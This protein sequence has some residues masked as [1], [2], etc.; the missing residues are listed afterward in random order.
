MPRRPGFLKFQFF[1]LPASMF[2][3]A[4]AI[5]RGSFSSSPAAVDVGGGKV[6]E[7]TVKHRELQ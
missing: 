5:I 6:V 2:I 3:I 4:W 1:S 7:D